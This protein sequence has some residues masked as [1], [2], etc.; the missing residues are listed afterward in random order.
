MPD[1]GAASIDLD[2][3][4]LSKDIDLARGVHKDAVTR[5]FTDGED[6]ELL[7]CI[8]HGADEIELKKEWA[9]KFPSTQL[10]RIGTIV[11]APEGPKIVDAKDRTPLSLGHGYEHLNNQD[12]H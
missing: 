1:E 8:E 12:E 4:L 7:F 10:T 2:C 3:L 6:Y 11:E 9:I 5:A